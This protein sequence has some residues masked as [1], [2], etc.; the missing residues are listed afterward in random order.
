MPRPRSPAAPPSSNAAGRETIAAPAELVVVMNAGVELRVAPAGL[1]SASG[2]DVASL[3]RVLEVEKAALLPLFGLSKDRLRAGV[4]PG[5][6]DGG[7]LAS[8]LAAYYRV[9]A[10]PARLDTLAAQLRAQPTVRAAYVKPPAEVPMRLGVA[11]LPLQAEAP[12]STPDFVARQGYL[13]VAPGGIDARYAWGRAGGRGTD[14]R[15]I[16]I[17]GAWRFSHEDLKQ[18][19]GGVVGGVAAN[20]LAWVN[21]GTA[22]VG[23]F[24]ADGNAF[25]VTGI[26]PDAD[27][28]AISIFGLSGSAAAIRM[29]ADLLQPGDIILLELHRPGPRFNFATRPDQAGYIAIEWWPD[30]YDAIRYAIARGVIVV[31]AAGNGGENL[32]DPIYNQAAPGFPAGWRNPFARGVRDSGAILVGAGA[33]PPGTHGADHGP[34]RSRLDFSN[35]GSAIDAQGWG[36]Q[37]TTCGYGD[38]QGG[39]NEDLWYTDQF[40]GTSSASPVVVGALG[41]VQGVLRARSIAPLTPQTAR[42]LLRATGSPQQDAPGRPASQRIGN[43]PDVRAMIDREVPSA[44]VAIPLYRY[45]NGGIGDH[46]YTTEWTEL[47]NGGW[48][49]VYEGIACYVFAAPAAGAAAPPGSLPLHRYWHPGFGNHFYTTNF[50]ELGA[51]RDG[52]IYEGV[53]CHVPAQPGAGTVPLYRYFN[54]ALTD[55]CYTTNWGELGYG[56]YG[57]ELEGIQ[58]QVYAQPQVVPAPG[59]PGASPDVAGA[60]APPVAAAVVPLPSSFGARAQSPRADAAPPVTFRTSAAP[61]GSVTI[62]VQR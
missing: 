12:A 10:A 35:Y 44:A 43:R 41:C 4:A 33:P 62:V 13:D 38:L 16:D 46:F 27:V 39:S 22:V 61:P 23:V 54:G 15:I 56:R 24:G 58:C 3:A 21:H 49:W 2:A 55:H 36:V 1:S 57:W 6:A 11:V 25:G 8:D 14:V 30:D 5:A 7:D 60:P 9:D 59:R 20:D 26:C 34:D 18:N 52:W 19:Q 47:G 40:N 32:D 48:G 17:E 29:A 28:R 37:V 42:N 31:E 50:A 45:W 53:Q 51:G